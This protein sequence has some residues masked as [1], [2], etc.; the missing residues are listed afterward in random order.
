GFCIIPFFVLILG[1]FNIHP[2]I[3]RRIPGNFGDQNDSTFSSI[4]WTDDEKEKPPLEYV[5]DGFIGLRLSTQP[6]EVTSFWDLWNTPSSR[7]E[8]E[9]RYKVKN[10][11]DGKLNIS[12]TYELQDKND[13]VVSSAIASKMAEPDETI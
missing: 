11:T 9:W 3:Y 2:E 1:Y 5:S 8:Y 12:V 6:V 10:L 4:A 13:K 7:V